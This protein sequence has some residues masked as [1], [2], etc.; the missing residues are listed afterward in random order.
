MSVLNITSKV[1][2]DRLEAFFEYATIGIVV[3][4]EKGL[5]KMANQN[6]LFQFGYKRKEDVVGKTMD[7]LIPRQFD[8]LLYNLRKNVNQKLGSHTLRTVK[9]LFGTRKNGFEFPVEVSLSNFI[10]EEEMLVVAFVTDLSKK[11]GLETSISTLQEQLDRNNKILEA[12][13]N[14]TERRIAVSTERLKKELKEVEASRDSLSASLQKEKKISGTK[15]KFVSMASHEF[16]TPLSTILSS[17]S[18]LHRYSAPDEQDKRNKHIHRINNAVHNLIDILDEF[19]SI[20]KIE[21][22]QIEV[23]NTI[24]NIK[25]YLNGLCMEMQLNAKPQQKITYC[26]KGEEWVNTD[27]SL[28]RNITFNLLSNAIKFSNEQG[29]ISVESEFE[30]L[31]FKIHVRDNGIGISKEEQLRLFE[32]FFRASNAINIQGT[33]LGLHIVSKYVEMLKGRIS[34]SSEIEK[35]TC[36]TIN[37]QTTPNNSQK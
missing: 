15:S 31:N 18:L 24:F 27:A 5:I 25:E 12:L 32:R 20:G 35:G 2:N 14:E 19:L 1:V 26:H 6:I 9:E 4:D 33:G 13:N 17:A 29:L 10:S 34:F 28:L 3:S 30:R 22:G 21:E 36:F 8:E 37:F 11:K 7:I 16:R 23:R